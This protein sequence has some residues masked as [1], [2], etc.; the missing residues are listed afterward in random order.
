MKKLPE[1]PLAS[2]EQRAEAVLLHVDLARGTAARRL[3]S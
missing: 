3:D 1:R 2:K